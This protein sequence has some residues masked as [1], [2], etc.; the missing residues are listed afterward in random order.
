MTN[1]ATNAESLNNLEHYIKYKNLKECEVMNALQDNRVIS[2]N[3]ITAHDVY[4]SG[5]AISWL[6]N[7]WKILLT[8]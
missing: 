1:K 6:E 3:C 4:G 5:L 7:N 8:Y 2:D